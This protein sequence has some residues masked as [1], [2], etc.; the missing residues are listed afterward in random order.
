MVTLLAQVEQCLNSRPLIPLSSEPSDTQPLTP[1]H[2]LV[3]SNMLALPQ[4]DR[5]QVSGNR[6]KEFDLVQKHMQHIWS[7]W[8]PEYLQQLQARAKRLIVPP[9]SLEEGQLVII[10]E[11]NIPPDKEG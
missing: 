4:V 10:K 6:L 5:S 8:Y 9:V 2:F 1:G 3:G 7:R 11:D